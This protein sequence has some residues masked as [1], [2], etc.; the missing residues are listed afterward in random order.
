MRFLLRRWESVPLSKKSHV[1]LETFVKEVR[2]IMD[3]NSD[4]LYHYGVLGMKWG[5]RRARKNGTAYTYRSHGTK[6]YAKKAEAARQAGDKQKA[7][8]YDRYHKRSVELDRKMQDNAEKNSGKRVAAKMALVTG[9]GGSRT[10]EAVRAATGGSKYVSRGMAATVSLL[11]GPF[12]ATPM[13]AL[14]VRGVDNN[15]V[16]NKVSSTISKAGSAAT[17]AGTGAF[18]KYYSMKNEGQ[19]RAASK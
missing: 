7:A 11:T 5:V 19:K 1:K 15:S 13:R 10:Y 18:E 9:F 12:G 6:K 2:E 3:Y 17:N 8:K 16:K 4:E 14:Y